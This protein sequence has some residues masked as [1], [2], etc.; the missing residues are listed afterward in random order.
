MVRHSAVSLSFSA[1]VNPGSVANACQYL[2]AALAPRSGP[3]LAGAGP[4]SS[5]R[6]VMARHVERGMSSTSH[7]EGWDVVDGRIV[8]RGSRQG[9]AIWSCVGSGVAGHGGRIKV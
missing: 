2:R 7:R 6:T 5:T 4:T 9:K 3:A 8:S 1:A